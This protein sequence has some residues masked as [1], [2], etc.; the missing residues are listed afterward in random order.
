VK[1]I[2][3]IAK[4]TIQRYY[5]R[6]RHDQV[7][8]AGDMFIWHSES[9]EGPGLDWHTHSHEE[10]E[11]N[12][13]ICGDVEFNVEGY[14]YP[15]APGS[16][17]LIPSNSFHG[18]NP[19]S[20]R[21]Y[22]RIAVH[23]LPELLDEAE[24]AVFLKLFE[25]G[26]HYYPGR[27]SLNIG[28]FMEALLKCADMEQP[29]KNLSLKSRLV[30]LLSEILL[31]KSSSAPECASNDTRIQGVI[32]Y[33]GTHLREELSLGDISRRFNISKNHL[34]VLFRQ[35]T[36]TTVGRYIR[37]KRLGLARQEIKRGLHPA[38]AAYNAGFRDYSNF[39]RAYKSLY[40]VMPSVSGMALFTGQT[41][42]GL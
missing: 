24:Q 40:G 41:A 13:T 33:L 1:I 31:L 35:A 34:N 21:L 30:S 22:H 3:T 32:K 39:F 42:P 7:L 17:L 25:N 26:A 16:L 9:D 23:F 11:I 6:V 14:R 27:A 4:I 37:V 20:R 2:E 36:G 5:R 19:H 29:L 15:R 18:W 28:F 8:Q 10:Y 38:E 12:Y